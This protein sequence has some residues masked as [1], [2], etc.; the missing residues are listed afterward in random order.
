[1]D[2]LQFLPHQAISTGKPK[3]KAREV[4]YSPFT[5]IVDSHAYMQSLVKDIELGGGVI[6][7]K[8]PFEKARVTPYGFEVRLGGADPALVNARYLI[9]AAGLCVVGVAKDIEGLAANHIPQACFA[10]CNYYSYMG[11]VPFT[12]LIYPVPEKG[13]PDVQWVDKIDYQ[14]NDQ[15]KEKLAQAI[16]TYGP[17]CDPSKLA[18]TYSGIRPKL[19]TPQQFSTDFVIQTEKDHGLVGLVNLFG[20]E[21]PGLTAS[22]AIAEEVSS[23]VEKVSH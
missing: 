1:V 20:I 23:I 16:Q 19:G 17:E 8:T 7:Y 14:V 2:D 10:K 22:L 18:P 12:R 13:G 15:S 9:N 6:V 21:S 11:Q 4:L 3:L 5:G